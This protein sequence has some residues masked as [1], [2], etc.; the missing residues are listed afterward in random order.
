MTRISDFSAALRDEWKRS[1]NIYSIP[2]RPIIILIH[3][4]LKWDQIQIIIS[5][6]TTAD[7]LKMFFKLEDFFSQQFKSS[8]RVFTSLE[9]KL[10]QTESLKRKQMHKKKVVTSATDDNIQMVLEA[11]HHRHWQKPLKRAMGMC[12]SSLKNPL[13]KNGIVL[14][15]TMELHGKNISLA[16]FH[17]IN[18]KSKSWALFSLR[19]PCI[20]FATEAQQVDKTG[21]FHINQTLTFGLGLD[22]HKQSV[23]QHH[24]MATVVRMTRNVIFPPQFKTLQEWFHYAFINSEIDGE[25]FVFLSISCN[26]SF[27]FSQMLTVFRF[28]K[29]T[30]E[31]Q[32]RTR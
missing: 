15:G 16:C 29:R 10:H 32:T 22:A 24:S 18:F 1:S 23:P 27:S 12:V 17:G 13:P 26:N 7:I 20:N 21:E 4:D 14:G 5:R 31:N 9:P 2:K 25:R 8:K 19:E 11:S 28:S 30:L 6:S 3:G